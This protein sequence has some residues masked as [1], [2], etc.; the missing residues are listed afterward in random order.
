MDFVN[1]KVLNGTTISGEFFI[2]NCFRKDCYFK[3][4]AE[5]NSSNPNEFS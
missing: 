5:I 2:E 1:L 3:I 4:I